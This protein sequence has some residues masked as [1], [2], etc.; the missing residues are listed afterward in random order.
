MTEVTKKLMGMTQSFDMSY[1]TGLWFAVLSWWNRHQEI[2]MLKR[3]FFLFL[4][5]NSS[6]LA[7]PC[8]RNFSALRN[9]AQDHTSFCSIKRVR[10][11]FLTLLCSIMLANL[12][13][14]GC[15]ALPKS[16]LTGGAGG[17]SGGD[18][19]ATTAT[20]TLSTTGISF[21]TVAVKGSIIEHVTVGA[22]GTG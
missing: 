10:A 14:T 7:T 22:S 12:A 1:Y 5:G 17:S 8:T 9:D 15:A 13:I 2:L 11:L 3:S 20:L 6:D 16:N 19:A 21:G 18:A 4:C